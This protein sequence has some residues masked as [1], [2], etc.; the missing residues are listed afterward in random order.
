MCVQHRWLTINQDIQRRGGV[1]V[2]WEDGKLSLTQGHYIEGIG[3]D[4]GEGTCTDR[5]CCSSE[6][7][8]H[9]NARRMKHVKWVESWLVSVQRGAKKK[10]RKSPSSLHSGGASGSVWSEAS[11]HTSPRV[12]RW[13]SFDHLRQGNTEGMRTRAS[14]RESKWQVLKEAVLVVTA[15]ENDGLTSCHN[16][17]AVSSKMKM[18]TFHLLSE[19]KKKP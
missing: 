4:G 12:T 11:S 15:K 17:G 3:I 9:S 19:K 18:T 2:A 10:K 1:I 6:F 13:R 16:N 8:C 7:R 5:H 14:G